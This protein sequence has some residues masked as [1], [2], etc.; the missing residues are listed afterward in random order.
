MIKIPKSHIIIGKK[1]LNK[2]EF[3]L[4]K[5]N[6]GNKPRGGLW[7]SPYHPDKEYISGWHEWC[8]SEMDHWLSNDSVVLEIKEDARIFTIDSQDDLIEFIKIIGIA[9]DELTKTLK[10]KML[11]YP[12]FEKVSQI[13]D[14]VYLTEEGQWDTR[15]SNNGCDYNLYGW[16]CES[17]LILN[18]DCIKTWEYKKLDIVKEDN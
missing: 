6:L 3:K 17:I 2:E 7:A 11:S 14:V 15:F 10:F 16:D 8:S 4:I 12:D 9:E 5:N 18:Y 1:E 13:F